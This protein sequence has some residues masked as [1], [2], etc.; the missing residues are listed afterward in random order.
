MKN[1]IVV[2]NSLQTPY[3]AKF[4]FSSYGPRCSQS[5]RVQDYLKI[6][7][8]LFLCILFLI[9]NSYILILMLLL[10][11]HEFF[12]IKE[13][14]SFSVISGEIEANQFAQIC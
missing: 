1:H 10:S 2:Y 6:I 9:S 3:L 8:F 5:I 7:F 4:S 14:Q 11:L 12:Y 13:N